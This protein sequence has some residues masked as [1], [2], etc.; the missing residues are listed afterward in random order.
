LELGLINSITYG[1]IAWASGYYGDWML[2]WFFFVPTQILI[3]FAWKNNLTSKIAFM[4]RLG[5]KAKIANIIFGLGLIVGIAYLLSF[6]DGWFIT[7][8]K[9]NGTVY[10]NLTT[11]F[12]WKYLGPTLD[13]A[14][15]IVQIFAQIFLIMRLFEQW[16][17]WF[18]S[19]IISIIIWIA[20]IITDKASYGYA[21][22]TLVMW[23]AY[24]VNSIYG[25]K[26]WLKGSKIKYGIGIPKGKLVMLS[27]DAH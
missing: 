12:G 10:G 9:R 22:P 11:M 15:V 19:N 20:V 17:L 8:L 3:Y 26:I 24:L 2:N 7:A 27:G 18:T 25:S 14:A 4:K 13:S 5:I 1:A 23:V 16:P 21:I 6:V